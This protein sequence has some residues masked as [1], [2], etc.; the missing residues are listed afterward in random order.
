MVLNALAV[1][2]MTR[3]KGGWRYYGSEDML[4]Q[5]CH[6]CLDP[7]RIQ[8]EGITLS[9]F[10]RLAQCQGCFVEMKQPM[11]AEGDSEAFRG[12]GTEGSGGWHAYG[13]DEFRKDIVELL[14]DQSTRSD[15]KEINGEEG[16]EESLPGIL[17]VSFGR[18]ALQQTGDGHFSPIAA[19]HTE[20]DQVLVMDVARFK[21]QHYWVKVDTLYEAMKL[22]DKKTQQPR[23]W[24]KMYAPHC[25]VS[26]SQKRHGVKDQPRRSHYY[27]LDSED[28]RDVAMVPLAGQ[29]H[30][31]PVHEIKVDYC[32]SRALTEPISTRSSD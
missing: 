14:S 13:V 31:C 6:G 5:T 23:G 15:G 30:P 11:V 29:G 28:R 7:V 16:E 12:Q 21:Y 19:Y 20:T 17:V 3:W 25:P 22:L 8:R 10:Q 26:S 2:P 27:H 18:S 4:L 24:F 9:E 1:D 32:Q